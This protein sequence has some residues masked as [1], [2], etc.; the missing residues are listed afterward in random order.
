MELEKS[1]C[2][3]PRVHD[4]N[5]IQVS[6]YLLT[7]I[8]RQKCQYW[9]IQQNLGLHSLP[10]FFKIYFKNNY[11]VWERSELQQIRINKV[12]SN[13]L[14]ETQMFFTPIHTLCAWLHEGHCTSCIG[15]ECWHVQNCSISVWFLVLGIGLL[16]AG[17]S[18]PDLNHSVFSR[19]D[20]SPQQL[21]MNPLWF[22]AAWT[23]YPPLDLASTSTSNEKQ[24]WQYS[25]SSQP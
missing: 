22:L 19:T 7:N 20:E 24:D 8:T 6:N 10:A 2:S 11:T 23:S 4:S 9:T 15:T 16:R 25:L 14:H 12:N 5:S 3:H 1:G 21:R 18:W 17:E 13:I